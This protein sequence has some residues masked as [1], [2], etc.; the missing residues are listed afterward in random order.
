MHHLSPEIA[1]LVAD[2]SPRSLEE[3]TEF[4]ESFRLNHSHLVNRG[5]AGGYRLAASA[6]GG[7]SGPPVKDQSR[8]P[9]TPAKDSSTAGGERAKLSPSSRLCFYCK[10]P[11]HIKAVC[12]QLSEK[13]P[14]VLTSTP[15]V[16]MI[17]QPEEDWEAEQ[18]KSGTRESPVPEGKG[19][20]APD[21]I[22]S[23]PAVATSSAVI[24]G[25]VSTGAAPSVPDVKWANSKFTAP[26][27]IN[28]IAVNSFRDTGSDITSVPRDLVLPIQMQA[29]P[30]KI[31]P[32]GVNEIFQPTAIV[33]VSYK[34]YYGNHLTIVHD[35]EVC[36]SPVLV[37]NDWGFKVYQQ[38]LA[39]N[40]F[41]SRS[42]PPRYRGWETGEQHLKV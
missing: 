2:Q 8:G 3:A 1:S 36:K 5:P 25:P 34:G 19:G 7:R 33:P 18:Q 35:P 24:V 16:R 23:K 38:Q 41:P 39:V 40:F 42:Y 27:E 28:G 14:P 30:L 13:K 31:S 17:Q 32:Y 37:G 21:A 22:A 10:K 26:I 11:G 29:K 20:A 15:A 6:S 9:P 4:A 12:P